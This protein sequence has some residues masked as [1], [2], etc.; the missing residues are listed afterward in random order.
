MLLG[1]VARSPTWPACDPPAKEVG[2][3]CGLGRE[4][5]YHVNLAALLK[6]HAGADREGENALRRQLRVLPRSKGLGTAPRS[7]PQSE[8]RNFPRVTGNTEAGSHGSCRRS[9]GAPGTAMAAFTNIP[10]RIVSR[11]AHYERSFAPKQE[12]TSPRISPWLGRSEEKG[13]EAG[14]RHGRSRRSRETGPTIPIEVA[15]RLMEEPP[16]PPAPAARPCRHPMGPAPRRTPSDARPV[17]ARRKK[18][19]SG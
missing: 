15:L 13:A 18:G 7:G 2:R 11:I 8:P 12:E 19:K 5:G 3:K 16:A 1:L 17:M 6:A 9:G 4:A 10:L 14:E